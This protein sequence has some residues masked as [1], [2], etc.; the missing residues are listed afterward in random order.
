MTNKF[1]Q[2]GFFLLSVPNNKIESFVKDLPRIRGARHPLQGS[3]SYCTF[4]K[5][6]KDIPFN[7]QSRQDIRGSL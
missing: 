6:R 2:I 3:L 4:V 5:R 7:R 1:V